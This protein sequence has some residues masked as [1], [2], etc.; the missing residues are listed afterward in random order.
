ASDVER[1]VRAHEP[2]EEQ[3]T[4]IAQSG[5]A[6]PDMP[7]ALQLPR[8]AS[9]GRRATSDRIGFS[10]FFFGCSSALIDFSVVRYPLQDPQPPSPPHDERAGSPPASTTVSDARR[11]GRW[12]RS[13]R[14]SASSSDCRCAW[15][16]PPS[17]NAQSPCAAG[18]WPT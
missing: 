14:R 3:P 18:V 1:E 8:T 10:Y 15:R 9:S 2:I 17:Q 6:G 13:P 16:S 4:D 12:R 7:T 5:M 11:G